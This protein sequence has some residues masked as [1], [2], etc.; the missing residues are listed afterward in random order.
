MDVS[1][2]AYSGDKSDGDEE[3][4]VM[5][6]EEGCPDPKPQDENYSATSKHYTA[7]RG[8]LVRFVDDIKAVR[9]AEIKKFCY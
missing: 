6:A 8:T 5:E 9:D 2:E 1:D 4:D 7:V 3:P